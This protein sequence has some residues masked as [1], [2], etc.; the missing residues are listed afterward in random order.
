MPLYSYVCKSCGNSEERYLK[1]SQYDSSV[2]C[3]VCSHVLEKLV[4]AARVSVDYEGYECPI[5]GKWIEGK[6]EHREN[7]ARH[8]KRVL[9]KG[10]RED[11]QKERQREE[12]ELDRKI[13]EDIERQVSK[14]STQEMENLARS[15][16]SSEIS[17]D[18]S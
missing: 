13:D 17:I 11:L 10:E 14:L 15:V 4:D 7:L 5:T 9:E 3:S 1:I 18:R 6:K 12:E 16:L 2:E 8:G